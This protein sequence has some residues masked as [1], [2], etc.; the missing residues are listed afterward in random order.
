MHNRH[1]SNERGITLRAVRIWFFDIAISI[2]YSKVATHLI[3]YCW[4][5]HIF[6][7][8]YHSIDDDYS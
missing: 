4:V 1:N 8:Y 5:I 2:S 3:Y 6:I 7:L